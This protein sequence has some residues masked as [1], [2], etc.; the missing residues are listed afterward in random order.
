MKLNNSPFV[1]VFV[2][3]T[4]AG[5]FTN[6]A[7]DAQAAA[8]CAA[9]INPYVDL[10]CGKVLPALVALSVALLSHKGFM[11]RLKRRQKKGVT[12]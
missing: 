7:V 4:V 1:L 3:G 8:P 9:V 11:R 2:A 10:I 5:I 12:R 6:A